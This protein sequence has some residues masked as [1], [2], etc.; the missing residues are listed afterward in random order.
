MAKAASLGG[1]AMSGAFCH[2]CHDI[3]RSLGAKFHI[4]HAKAVRL[5]HASGAEVIAPYKTEEVK[6][7]A[8]ASVLRF[9][10]MPPPEKSEKL[11]IKRHQAP[12]GYRACPA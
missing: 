6:Y 8:N 1:M 9:Q 12:E 10:R 4:P 7:I 11:L 2:L 3:G 5:H